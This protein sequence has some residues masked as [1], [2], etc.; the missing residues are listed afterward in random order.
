[1]CSTLQLNLVWRGNFGSRSGPLFGPD[2]NGTHAIFSLDCHAATLYK[3]GTRESREGSPLDTHPVRL[4][5]PEAGAP[6]GRVH[7]G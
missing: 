6:R 2:A 5:R 1:M 3:V 7:D 4:P